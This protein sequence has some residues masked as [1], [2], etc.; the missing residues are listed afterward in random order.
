[1]RRPHAFSKHLAGIGRSNPCNFIV[2]APSHPSRA[3]SVPERVGIG[4]HADTGVFFTFGK[5]STKHDKR[6]GF[7]RLRAF[8]AIRQRFEAF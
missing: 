6:G 4:T 5:S 3:P 8:G 7:P 2:L 1:M